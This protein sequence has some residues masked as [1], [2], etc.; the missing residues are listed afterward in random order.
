MTVKFKPYIMNSCLITK[1]EDFSSYYKMLSSL[2]NNSGNSYITYGLIK[3]LYGKLVDIDHMNFLWTKQELNL[4]EEL[5]KINAS[6]HVFLILQDFIRPANIDFRLD[7]QKIINYIKKINKPI[8]IP[9]IGVNGLKYNKDF[10]KHLTPELKQ[11]LYTISEHSEYIGVRGYLSKEVLSNLGIN[12]VIVTGCP[13]YFENGQNRIINKHQTISKKD[14]IYSYPYSITNITGASI[15]QGDRELNI[16]ESLSFNEKAILKECNNYEIINSYLKKEYSFFTNIDDWKNYLKKFK[17]FVGARVHGSIMAMNSGLNPIIFL[18]DIRAKEMMEY[19]KLPYFQEYEKEENILHL[20]EKCDYSEANKA[21][22][23]L[24]NNWVNFLHKNGCSM[25]YENLEMNNITESKQPPSIKLYTKH[26]NKE[27]IIVSLVDKQNNEL[28]KELSEI[29]TKLIYL[30]TRELKQE[31]RDRKKKQFLYSIF[32]VT[33]T[34]DAKHKVWC[35]LGIKLK[36]K[37]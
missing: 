24:Y 31:Q 20:F 19:F 15:I 33:N 34:P 27:D 3:S 6:S 32:S 1:T 11:F 29:K 2:D 12:N 21:Y 22:N 17:L 13:S 4:D 14:I 25:Y 10:H 23:N 26:M 36:L 5:E 28:K 8:I 16:I 9:N 35:I 7:Y 18:R 37:K 30:E